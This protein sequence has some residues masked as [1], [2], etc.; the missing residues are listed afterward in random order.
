VPIP[1]FDWRLPWPSLGGSVPA[2][3]CDW[4]VR[5]RPWEGPSARCHCRHLVGAEKCIPYPVPS[6]LSWPPASQRTQKVHADMPTLTDFL[7]CIQKPPKSESRARKSRR[8]R[9]TTGGHRNT[10]RSG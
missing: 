10:I 6:G 9:K 1:V 8:H 3:A 5:G 7:M 2:C 4:G